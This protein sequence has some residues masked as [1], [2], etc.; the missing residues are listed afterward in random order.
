MAVINTNI[1]AVRATFASNS[2]NKMLGISMQRLSTG[3]RIN[4]ANDDAAGLG[5]VTTM[6]AS[7]RGM[8]MAVRNTNDGISLAQTA[9]GVLSEVVNMVQR[10]R[11]LAVQS[12]S[13]TYVASDRQAMQE[14]VSALTEQIADTLA[15]STFNGKTLF[16]TTAGTDVTFDLQIGSTTTDV[17][18]ITSKAIDGTNLDATALDVTTVALARTTLDNAD[19]A[20]DDI[21][22]A[23]STLGAAQNRLESVANNLTTNVTSLSDARSRIEDTDYSTETAAM[24]KAQILSQASTAMIAQANQSAQ[25]VMSL[26]R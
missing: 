2:A 3:K 15:N 6:T 11:E 7:I 13:E 18:T 22:A 17:M 1:A 25:N 4:G 8:N 9:D 24:A 26:L 20:L 23:R 21:N 14:E 5:I 12:A 19:A 10:V 16:S